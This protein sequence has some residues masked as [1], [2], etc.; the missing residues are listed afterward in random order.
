[1]LQRASVLH[2]V[3]P[4][5]FTPQTNETGEDFAF[6]DRAVAA[7]C[8][9]VVAT[10]CTVAHVDASTGPAFVPGARPGWIVNNRILLAEEFT[11]K[12]DEQIVAHFSTQREKRTYVR[13]WRQLRNTCVALERSVAAH[14]RRDADLYAQACS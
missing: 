3:G 2:R 9:L 1:M 8:N 7:G 10:G 4:K 5:P 12:T 13:M 6:C 11:G 14:S